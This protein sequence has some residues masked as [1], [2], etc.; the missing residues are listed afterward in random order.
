MSALPRDHF[1]CIDTT[2]QKRFRRFHRSNPADETFVGK[3]AF[4]EHQKRQV[5]A[6]FLVTFVEVDS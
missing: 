1:T 2:W 3:D 6:K 5:P 4:K